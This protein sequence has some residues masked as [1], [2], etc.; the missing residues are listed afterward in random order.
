MRKNLDTERLSNISKVTIWVSAVGSLDSRAYANHFTVLTCE[1]SEALQVEGLEI[2][3][4]QRGLRVVSGNTNIEREG[5]RTE[6]Q[7]NEDGPMEDKGRESF[8]ELFNSV[9]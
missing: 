6:D 1:S 7:K 9:T 5:R 8:K 4:P 3:R 2:M